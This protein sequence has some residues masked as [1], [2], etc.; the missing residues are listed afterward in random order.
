MKRPSP[1]SIVCGS[2]HAQAHE[3]GS[4]LR[5]SG[6][7][8]NPRAHRSGRRAPAGSTSRRSCA[9]ARR[10]S[11][12]RGSGQTDRLARSPSRACA[13]S[14]S[15][16]HSWIR[17]TAGSAKIEYLADALDEIVPRGIAP[18]SSHLFFL[19]RTATSLNAGRTGRGSSTD[20]RGPR[21]RDDDFVRDG[22]R[23]RPSPK[24]RR[25][26]RPRRN[27]ERRRVRHGSGNPAAVLPGRGSRAPHRS[28]EEGQCL[29]P[30]RRDT[31]E[32][33]VV[34]LQSANARSSPRS[35]MVRGPQ[36]D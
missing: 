32:D 35:S 30:R 25:T 9:N 1:G 11:S 22:A 14:P 4:R 15:I 31:I 16:R 5:S 18:W 36:A 6:Q 28:G 34:A 7:G 24:R 33:R 3:G 17:R 2:L 10:S 20:R 8:R 12:S 26:D 19:A 27:V 23:V 13:S 29:P 21:R